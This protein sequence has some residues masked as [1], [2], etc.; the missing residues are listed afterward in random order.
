[1]VI[2][3]QQPPQIINNRYRLGPE[4][5]SG[6]VSI[7]YS[8]SL[9]ETGESVALLLAQPPARLDS[10][11]RRKLLQPVQALVSLLHPHLVHVR[12]A[13]LDGSSCFI[14]T[15]L[16]GRPL[17]ELMES[18]AP[19]IKRAIEIVWQLS[20]G[21]SA[22]HAQ[23]IYEIDARPERISIEGGEQN[24]SARAADVGIRNFLW[25]LGFQDA[26][27]NPLFQ[28]DPRYAAPEQLR[29]A[30]AGPATDVYTLALLLF[31]LI[32]G[33]PPFEGQTSAE[34]RAMQLSAPVPALQPLRGVAWAELQNFIEQALAKSPA[35]RFKDMNVFAQALVKL[36]A[37]LPQQGSNPPTQARTFHTTLLDQAVDDMQS[38]RPKPVPPPPSALES[39]DFLDRETNPMEGQENDEE[40][41]TL[42][43]PGRARLLVGQSE[44]KK[45]IPIARL[46]VTL[47]RADP[48]R[49]ISPDIDLSPYDPKRSI[50]RKHARIM[51]EGELF[52]IED[53]KSRNKTWLGELELAPYERQL[54]RRHDTI[55]LGLL[56]LTF[57]Y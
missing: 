47:G 2:V 44:R 49:K 33:Q 17:R 19:P 4:L 21:L 53:L 8:A 56:E 37:S 46:P 42:H 15:D 38:T 9:I 26:S 52:Y 57:E 50:S 43:V 5:I 40:E 27:E 16:R 55:Q 14:V 13:G 24:I 22:L 34:T 10:I 35:L 39:F 23:G 25:S 30:T 54:L 48:H 3:A 11:Q 31:E 41:K 6:T 18:G 28:L 12:E 20:Q 7:L 36:T 45:V 51:R 1:V 32:A 29:Q